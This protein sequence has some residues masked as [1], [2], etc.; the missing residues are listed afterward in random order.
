MGKKRAVKK[1]NIP[2]GTFT[3]HWSSK[4]YLNEYYKPP[5]IATD[6]IEAIRFQI[7]ILKSVGQKPLALEFGSGPTAHRVIAA[8]P[9]FSEIHIVDYLEEN[10]EELK[11]WVCKEK[12]SHRWDHYTKYILQC[13][14]IENPTPEQISEREKI[15]RE[16]ITHFIQADAGTEHPLGK[17]Y[18]NYYQHIFS[19]FCADSAT[20]DKKTWVRYMHNIA[21]LVAPGG[22][23]FTA[24]LRKAK[25]YRSGSNYFPSA[26]VD[27]H[28]IR[29]VL[30]L[31]FLPESIMIVVKEL[32]E[33]S[34]EGYEGIVLAY[35]VKK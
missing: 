2:L 13:E 8:A 32:P 22:T 16:K 25:Y 19:G 21:S 14:G 5:V 15:T 18:A 9:Y 34:S 6:E 27:E 28:D 33:L 1:P 20:G 23:F 29:N 11:R 7:E 35:A 24:A 31:D 4:D 30:E 17:K 3:N 26:N 12:D 10:L